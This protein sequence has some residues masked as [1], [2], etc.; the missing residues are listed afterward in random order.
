MYHRFGAFQTNLLVEGFYT[1]LTDVFVLGG[2]FDRGDGVLVKI[3]SNGP[4]AKVMGLTLEGKIAYL[5]LLQIQAGL[6]LQRSRYDEPHKWHDDAPAERK[7]FRTPDIYGYFTA[8]YTPVKPLSIALGYIYRQY[9]CAAYGHQRRKRSNGRY[10]R[11]K[12]GSHPYTPVLR[13]GSEDSV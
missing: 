8:T 13:Y 6:T 10:A 5:S 1:R 12:G 4:G 7:I 11:A 3:R 2:P 9:A